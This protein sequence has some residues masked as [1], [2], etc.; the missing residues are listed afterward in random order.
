[1]GAYSSKPVERKPQARNVVEP[2]PHEKYA[3]SEKA[4]TGPISTADLDSWGND[5]KANEKNLLAQN[6]LANNALLSVA[7]STVFG[8][9]L[10]NRFLFNT[11][12][13]IVGL[14]LSGNNQKSSGRCWLFA[15]CNVLRSAVI[16]RYN[17]DPDFQLSQSYLFFYDKLEKA[18]Y[19]L[20]NVVGASDE[21]L[22][23]RLMQFLLSGSVSDGG[24]WDMVVNLLEKY[25]AVPLEAFPDNAQATLTSQLNYFLSNK[26][27]EYALELRSLDKN[28]VEHAK[29]AMRRE[30]FRIIALCLGTPPTPATLFAWEYAD[31]DGRHH[32]VETTPLDFY[33]VHVDF[34]ASAHFSLVHDPRNATGA[35]YTVDKLNNVAEGRPIGYVNV[36][37][38]TMKKAA[39][40]ALKNN[41]AVFF[42][43]DV[44]KFGDRSTGVLDTGAYDYGLVFGTDMKLSKEERLRTGSSAMTHAMVLTGVHL[45]NG[46]VRWK[47]ENSWGDDV[48]SKGYFLM[49]DAW[50]DEYVFQVVTAKKYV[51]R[52][53]Y[54]VWRLKEYRVLPYYDPLGALA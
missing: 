41:E 44:G 53:V 40:A 17:L 27:R 2:R 42:G 26:L 3:V 32:R 24:Q 1:M 25:G 34:S 46:A 49:T 6:A 33:K 45:E 38:A 8:D 7:A 52:D 22:D 50:F 5:L 16:K 11:Q 54:D 21:A 43:C 12:V 31:K 36:D 48:G 14:P 13:D 29:A 15:T 18:S 39:I 9:S 28:E 35:L 51:A 30:I 37:L 4:S 10:R 20:D 23:S 19:F 47:I